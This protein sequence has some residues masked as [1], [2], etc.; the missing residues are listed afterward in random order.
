MQQRIYAVLAMLLFTCGV[1]HAASTEHGY[2]NNEPAIS[3]GQTQKFLN[4]VPDYGTGKPSPNITHSTAGIAQ[5]NNSP[6][7][8]KGPSVTSTGPAPGKSVSVKH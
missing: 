1:A 7:A 5:A 3:S 4:K 8:V 6:D 2:A